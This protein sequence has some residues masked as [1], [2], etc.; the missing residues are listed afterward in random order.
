[1]T[2]LL[3]LALTYAAFTAPLQ[4]AEAPLV[5]EAIV[6]APVARVWEAFATPAGYASVGGQA[7][8]DLKVRGALTVK[9]AADAPATV[10]EILSFEPERLLS[11]RVTQPPP[12][13]GTASDFADTW[14]VV[15]FTP[16]GDMTHV[17][18]AGFGFKTPDLARFFEQDQSAQLKRI[19]KLYWPLCELCKAEGK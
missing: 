12:P 5:T 8:V 2:R 1:M 18:V 17:R 7:T 6:N 9:D 15:Y 4:A 14:T 10:S 3:A 11:I 13:F 19:E 16:L